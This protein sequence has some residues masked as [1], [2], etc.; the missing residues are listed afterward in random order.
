MTK[1]IC[2]YVSSAV[3]VTTVKRQPSIPQLTSPDIMTQNDRL[4]N[5]VACY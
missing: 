3:T 1:H 5:I 4:F 2:A